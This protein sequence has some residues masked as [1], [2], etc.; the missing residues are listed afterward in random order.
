MKKSIIIL[1]VLTMTLASFKTVQPEER[2]TKADAAGERM[3]ATV[4][5]AFQHRSL[6]EYTTLFPSIAAFHE[7]MEKNSA[8]YGG[9]IEEAKEEFEMHYTTEVLPALNQ[10]FKSIIAQ[11]MKAGIDW[12]TIKLVSV[13][14][15]NQHESTTAPATITFSSKGKEYRLHF[16]KTILLNGEWRVSQYLRLI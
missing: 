16:E 11:G 1:S 8:F 3:A 15:D 12:A 5:T 7:I 14:F 13:E 6:E 9:N 2:I 10:S 4:V